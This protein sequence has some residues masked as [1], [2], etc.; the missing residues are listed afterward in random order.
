MKKSLPYITDS[1]IEF[2]INFIENKAIVTAEIY[3]ENVYFIS[4]NELMEISNTAKIKGIEIVELRTNYGIELK[5][6]E[7][8]TSV[9]FNA[10]KKY[11][12]NN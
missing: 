8:P 1:G 4:K 7:K 3:N 11:S 5:K 9:G 12:V 6:S 2:Y 10:I